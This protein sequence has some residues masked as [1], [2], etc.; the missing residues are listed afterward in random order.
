MTQWREVLLLGGLLIGMIACANPGRV[1]PYDLGVEAQDRGEIAPALEYYKEMLMEHPE[2]LRARF[3][4]AVLYHDRQR[5]AEAKYHYRAL[6]DRY[7]RHARSMV[8]LA[9]IALAE[10][11]PTQAHLHLLRAVET[12]PDR[13]YPYSFLGRFLQLQGQ[14]ELAQ[15]AYERAL[16]IEDDAMTHYRYGLFWLE[17]RNLPTAK[18]QFTQAIKRDPRHAE[19]LYELAKLTMAMGQPDEAI[20]YFQRVSKLTPA[21]ADVFARLGELY[22]QQGDYATAALNLWEARDL[23]PGTPAVERL[24]LQVYQQLVQQQQQVVEG[25]GKNAAASR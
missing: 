19:A 9:D 23:E 22:L 17:V 2:H 14:R 12:E 10:G 18:A 3:N 25:L 4:L 13:A 20:K 5:Y 1:T 21:R 15:Q 8:N 24:L 6:L 16:A 11:R 7:P